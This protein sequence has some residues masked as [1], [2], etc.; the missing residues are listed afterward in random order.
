M[1]VLIFLLALVLRS[2]FAYDISADNDY[3]VSGGSDSYYWRRIIDYSV[4]TGDSLYW[5]SLINFPDGLRNPRPPF[6][7]M[8]V[9]VPAVIAA[10]MFGSVSDSIGFMFVWS[11][12]FWGALTVVP[13]YM[14]GRETFG[15]RAGL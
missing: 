12:A 9:A 4:E 7:S 6:Y 10:D 14:L 13:V 15:R 3:I 2:Y 11:T 8:S 1:L 5:D